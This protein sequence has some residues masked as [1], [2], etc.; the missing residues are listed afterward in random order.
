M[1]DWRFRFVALVL[2]ALM[3]PDVE[4]PSWPGLKAWRLFWSRGTN[5]VEMDF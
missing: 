4:S 5:G 2:N 1:V 3:I